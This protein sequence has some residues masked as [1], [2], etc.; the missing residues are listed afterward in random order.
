[1]SLAS[2]GC[3]HAAYDGPLALAKP[4]ARP[5]TSPSISRT[6]GTLGKSLARG[7]QLGRPQII[8]RAAPLAHLLPP[9]WP[10]SPRISRAVGTLGKSLALERQSGR[11]QIVGR[12]APLAHLLSL[13]WPPSPRISRAVGTLGTL[14]SPAAEDLSPVKKASGARSR[15]IAVGVSARPSENL[16]GVPPRGSADR[17][18]AAAYDTRELAWLRRRSEVQFR[19]GRACTLTTSP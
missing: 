5:P 1:M 6:V 16:R 13:S 10:T 2:L 14:L 17:S 4:V 8:G 9:S 15:T 11:P 12:A 3:E 7:R 19:V 18:R